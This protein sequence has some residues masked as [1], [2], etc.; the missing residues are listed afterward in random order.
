MWRI[1]GLVGCCGGGR[2]RSG[3]GHE[4][5]DG[6]GGGDGERRDIASCVE[7][8]LPLC[9]IHYMQEQGLSAVVLQSAIGSL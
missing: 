5:G 7:W 1:E 9:D 2:N 6:D 8:I 3:D 4:D